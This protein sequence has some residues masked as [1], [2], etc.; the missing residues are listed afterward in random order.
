MKRMGAIILAAAIAMLPVAGQSKA[1]K[2]QTKAVQSKAT[3][4]TRD[5]MVEALRILN[6]CRKTAS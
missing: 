5:G 1:A 4:R 6:A 2:G 3:P